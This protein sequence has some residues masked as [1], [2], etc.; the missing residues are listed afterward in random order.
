MKRYMFIVLIGFFLFVPILSVNALEPIELTQAM[1]AEADA[2]G[3]NIETDDGIVKK[4]N[5]Y[6]IKKPGDYILGENLDVRGIE[7]IDGDYTLNLNNK[8]LTGTIESGSGSTLII[9]GEGTV[10]KGVYAGTATS[11]TIKGG[12]YAGPFVVYGDSKVVVENGSFGNGDNSY[13][14]DTHGGCDLEIKG[15]TF[16]FNPDSYSDDNITSVLTIYQNVKIIISGGVFKGAEYGI[17]IRPDYEGDVILK[18]GTFEGTKAAIYVDGYVSG[19]TDNLDKIIGGLL[20]DGYMYSPE[21]TVIVEDIIIDPLTPDYTHEIS[22]T[23]EKSLQVVEKPVEPTNEEETATEERQ[24]TNNPKTYD[25]INNY[26]LLLII[27][28]VVLFKR[29]KLF[30]I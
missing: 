16:T 18:G 20:D 27:S 3:D 2:A 29:K 8:N 17:K 4:L 12:T 14:I 10:G 7:F 24:E 21:A 15:G 22:R 1:F 30:E 19:T 6:E 23:E 26:V 25:N 13:V 5:Y 11:L 9:D 28:L